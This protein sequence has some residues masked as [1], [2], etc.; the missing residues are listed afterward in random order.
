MGD[1]LADDRTILLIYDHSNSEITDSNFEFIGI[2]AHALKDIPMRMDF[3]S[4]ALQTQY[5]QLG[6][7]FL[8]VIQKALLENVWYTQPS[9]FFFIDL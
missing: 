8:W 7:V 3:R 5:L 1:T 9:T 2:S 4:R 6:L